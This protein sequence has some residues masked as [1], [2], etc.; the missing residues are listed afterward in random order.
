MSTEFANKYYITAVPQILL[1]YF[2]NE[3]GVVYRPNLKYKSDTDI[4]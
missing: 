3:S 4:P 2:R 1:I